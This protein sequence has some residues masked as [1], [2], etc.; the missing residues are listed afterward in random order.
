MKAALRLGSS[1]AVV[2]H[3]ERRHTVSEVVDAFSSRAHWKHN[4]AIRGLLHLASVGPRQ[5]QCRASR[6]RPA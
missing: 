2:G 3:Q 6:Q 5:I 1:E 4:A